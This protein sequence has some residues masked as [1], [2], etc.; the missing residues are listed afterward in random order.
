[1]SSRSLTKIVISGNEI[2]VGKTDSDAKRAVM[3]TILIVILGVGLPVA[4]SLMKFE[5]LD[6]VQQRA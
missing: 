6:N 2:L 3:G 1:M 4:L 5:W